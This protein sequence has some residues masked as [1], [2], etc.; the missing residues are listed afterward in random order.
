MIAFFTNFLSPTVPIGWEAWFWALLWAAL[1]SLVLSFLVAF[2]F[3]L[4]SRIFRLIGFQGSDIFTL[5]TRILLKYLYAT[6]MVALAWTAL[7]AYLWQAGKIKP[8]ELSALGP[9]W[10]GILTA[11][12]F[13]LALLAVIHKKIKAMD[14]SL[15]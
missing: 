6:I 12:I 13:G 5:E 11:L 10:F 7:I 9:Y 15:N 8:S 1:T 14:V 3:D 2:I 4:V